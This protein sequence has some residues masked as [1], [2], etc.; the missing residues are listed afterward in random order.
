MSPEEYYERQKYV[1]ELQNQG[2]QTW[3]NLCPSCGGE[4]FEQID[5]RENLTLIDRVCPSCGFIDQVIED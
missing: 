5:A 1:Y 3:G 4:L 2:Y